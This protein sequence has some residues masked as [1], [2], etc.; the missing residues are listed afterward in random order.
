MPEP[1][2]GTEVSQACLGRRPRGRSADPQ[3]PRCPPHHHR[4]VGRVGRREQEQ[5]PRLGRQRVNPLAKAFLDPPRRRQRAGEPE[6]AG[7]LRWRQSPRQLQQR[8]R[9]APGLSHDLVADPL[10]QRSGQ[11]RVQQGPRIL[12]L[13]PPDRQ[14]WQPRQL[15]AWNAGREDQTDRLRHQAPRHEGEHLR[16]GAIKP[17]GVV[18]QADQWAL[19][20]RLRQQAQDGQGDQEPVRRRPGMQTE[21]DPQRLPLRQRQSLVVNQ[22]RRAQLVQSGEGQL[23]L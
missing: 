4:I 3:Q 7:Q 1:H 14:L 21:R 23:H 12:L 11:H 18:D 16:G 13:Q 10:T 2:P 17:L 19:P 15:L 22:Q 8:Q 9:V 6:P 20:G 5:P